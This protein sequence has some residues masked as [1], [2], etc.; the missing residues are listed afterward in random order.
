MNAAD[1]FREVACKT[2]EEFIDE[3]SMARGSLWESARTSKFIA[4][5]WLLRGM[6]R[7]S[8]GLVPSAFRPNAFIPIWP[9]QAAY[10]PTDA[11]DQRNREDSFVMDFASEAD[12]MGH[13]LPSDRPELRDPRRAIDDYNPFEF[14]PIEKLHVYALAQH[15]GIPTRLLDWTTRPRVAAYFAVEHLA[16]IRAGQA[17]GE[18]GKTPAEHNEPCAVWALNRGFINNVSEK[19]FSPRVFLVTSAKATNPNLAAQGGLFTLVQPIDSDEHPLPNLDEVFRRNAASVPA[20]WEDHAPFLLKFTL[21]ATE[22]RVALRMLAAEGVHA[23]TVY[24][25]LGGVVLAMKESKAHQ[26]ATP[27]NRS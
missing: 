6:T 4:H 10:T 1:M 3:M 20:E 19:L 25:G 24:P 2:A 8:W 22:A 12:Q 21:P 9:G 27:G 5:D 13:A 15:Y 17:P 18:A 7:A 14:P 16:R 11:R 23:G 26:W